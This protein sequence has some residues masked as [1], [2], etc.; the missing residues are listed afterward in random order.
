[1]VFF[2]ILLTELANS[3]ALL[4][5]LYVYDLLQQTETVLSA[6]FSLIIDI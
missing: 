6:A 4:N 1:M 5:T 2:I 3:P